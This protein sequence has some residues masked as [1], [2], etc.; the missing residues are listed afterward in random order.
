MII[1]TEKSCDRDYVKLPKNIQT[2]AEKQLA[3]F[4]NNRLKSSV[5]SETLESYSVT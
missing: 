4:K 2:L 5:S 1:Q 3:L